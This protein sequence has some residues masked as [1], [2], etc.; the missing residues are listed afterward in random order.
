[1]YKKISTKL[2]FSRKRLLGYLL[3][4]SMV[5][6]HSVLA[7]ILTAVPVPPENPITQQKAVLGKILFWDEQLSSN[8][9]VACGTC[10]INSAAGADPRTNGIHPG[11]DG[12]LGNNDDVVGSLGIANIDSTGNPVNDPIFGLE[13]QV[14][15][16]SA[17]PIFGSLWAAD[18]FWDGRATSQFLDPANT[19][20]VIITSGGGLE[21]QA[22]GP[23]LSN[24]EMAKNGRTWAEVTTKLA[25]VTPMALANSLPADVT[26]AITNNVT[27]PTLFASAFGDN[28]ITPARIGMALATYERTLV[29]DQTPLNRFENGD[30]T[31]LS[32]ADRNTWNDFRTSN[33]Q[34]IGQCRNCHTPP[35][36]TNND[37]FYIGTHNRNDD[38][39]RQAIT[40]IANDRG[41]MKV[42]SLLNV[43]LKSTF[44]HT[45]QRTS[46]RDAVDFYNE[47][48][49]FRN[50]QDMVPNSGIPYNGININGNDR[51]RVT[52]FFINALTDPRVANETF[53]FDRPK[54]RSESIAVVSAFATNG[55][56]APLVS[57]YNNSGITGVTADNLASVNNAIA[58]VNGPAADTVTEIQ[59]IVDTTIGGNAT[60]NLDIDGNG[61]NDALTDGLLILRYMFGFRGD[62]L[63]NGAVAADAT[64][65]SNTDI[66]TMVNA[67]NFD[68][69][70][71]NRTDALTDGLLILRYLFG[72]RGDTLINGAVASDA[73]RTTSTAIEA[74]MAQ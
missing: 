28:A 39:G 22:V 46:V 35:L 42:P 7:Q 24:I 62:T 29:P 6:T 44:M 25:R 2:L 3:L 23:I 63:I 12:I 21:S 8:D 64:R 26:A 52:S 72:F 4:L 17:Q 34:G 37:F 49:R 58:A 68:I 13:P 19:A 69:D 61:R 27:Y 53:P 38:T 47:N 66:E 65:N 11:A 55:V 31:A 14:T 57:D 32:A 60:M 71:N 30:Q 50:Q 74:R 67:G 40:N 41:R 51:A 10:H 1:M 56:T 36:F 18:L 59:A 73:T 15:N 48:N 43:G 9:T 33:N 5:F 16:R 70:G 45:G 54:M 20:T